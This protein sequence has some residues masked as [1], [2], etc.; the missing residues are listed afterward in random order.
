MIQKLFIKPT[1][2]TLHLEKIFIYEIL[3]CITYSSAIANL[4]NI[5]CITCIQNQ[6]FALMKTKFT[7]QLKKAVVVHFKAVY[8]YIY[9]ITTFKIK[10]NFFII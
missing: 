3:Y 4:A 8:T 10:S 9:I 1:I 2:H 5:M 7:P 6:K